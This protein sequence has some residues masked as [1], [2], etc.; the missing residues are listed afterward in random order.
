MR[1]LPLESHRPNAE[2]EPRPTCD[3]RADIFL[4]LCSTSFVKCSSC[5]R[6]SIALEDE[7]KTPKVQNFFLDI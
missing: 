3:A 6:E 2:P 4:L 7:M 5:E 1:W